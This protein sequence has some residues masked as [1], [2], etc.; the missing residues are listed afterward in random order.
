MFISCYH[1]TASNFPKGGCHYQRGYCYNIITLCCSN[2]VVG[3]PPATKGTDNV[4]SA[5]GNDNDTVTPAEGYN[6]VTPAESNDIVTPS[7]G[8]DTVINVIMDGVR[9]NTT[10]TIY[11]AQLQSQPVRISA[12]E[13]N[14]VVTAE[15]V[16]L[17]QPQS[18]PVIGQLSTS[19]QK[20]EKY[21]HGINKARRQKYRSNPVP[22]KDRVR[23][24]YNLDPSP[25]RAIKREKYRSHPTPVKE[26]VRQ[27]YSLDP[28]PVRAMKR[29]KYRCNP[30]PVRAHK[31]AKY[32]DNPS[33]FKER[34]RATYRLS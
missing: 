27:A 24:A 21:K 10:T 20:W 5:K 15:S 26:R 8:D 19:Q 18:Q 22:E 7:E 31:R 33:P 6:T 32:Q 14:N 1:F 11:P 28:S 4:T 29:E 23:Q 25:V 34:A 9:D 30:S 17:P 3:K 13:G 2:T 16:I 12:P